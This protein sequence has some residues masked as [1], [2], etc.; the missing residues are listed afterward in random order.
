MNRFDEWIICFCTQYTHISSIT[1]ILLL[2]LLLLLV[3]NSYIKLKRTRSR[4]FLHIIF[5]LLW[6]LDI[7][8]F[9]VYTFSTQFFRFRLKFFFLAAICLACIS[10][11]SPSL[12]VWV[13]SPFHSAIHCCSIEK[14]LSPFIFVYAY[15][16]DYGYNLWCVTI[17]NLKH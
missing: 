1:S 13:V 10:F 8:L 2:F 14:S 4:S 7:D 6:I 9:L 15:S 12:S 3:F 16:K 5:S 17:Y 11:S